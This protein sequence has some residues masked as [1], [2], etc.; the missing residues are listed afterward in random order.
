[1]KEA[2]LR[3]YHRSTGIIIAV[4]VFFQA[5]TGLLISIH[6]I[7]PSLNLGDFADIIHF[8]HFGGGLGGNI[9]RILLALG[10]LF[11]AC[12]GTWIFFKI[13]SRTL[14]AVKKM[15]VAPDKP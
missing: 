1:M 13:R 6:R 5:L 3:K 11:M 14:A 2:D 4:F 15:P 12:T 8:G 9:Y 10:L 7:S